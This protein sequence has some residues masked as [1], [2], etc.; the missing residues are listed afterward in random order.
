ML[1]TECYCDIL[2]VK[3]IVQR[4]LTGAESGINR[5]PSFNVALLL[6]RAKNTVDL[7][8]INTIGTF[9]CLTEWNTGKNESLYIS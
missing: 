7:T 1:I 3:G 8:I 6:Y 4:E 2:W 5:Q 9:R